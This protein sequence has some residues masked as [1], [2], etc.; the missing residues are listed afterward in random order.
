MLQKKRKEEEEDSTWRKI[1]RSRRACTQW[2]MATTL[3][4][5]SQGLTEMP[6]LLPF[7]TFMA[8]QNLW[9][10]FLR[11]TESTISPDCQ[12]PD[13]RQLSFVP[14]FTSLIL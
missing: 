11:D 5:T 12:H 3:T 9:R 2:G 6:P 7:T 10:W 8:E 4:P 13:E 14:T 1:T